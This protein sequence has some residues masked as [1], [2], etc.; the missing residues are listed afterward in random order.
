MHR[1][2]VGVGVIALNAAK[3]ILLGQRKNAHGEQSWAP[4]GGHLEFGEDICVC[5]Q[6]ELEEETGLIPSHTE[7]LTF[8]NDIFHEEQLH[9]ITLFVRC[10]VGD[11]EPSLRE[12]D[13]CAAWEWFAL[14]ALPDNLFL[15]LRNLLEKSDEASI[16]F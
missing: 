6:R 1:P 2:R 4:P 15:P 14:H 11:G 3:K 7:V 13:K 10:A 16:H 5:A 9:Y 12:P 8:T